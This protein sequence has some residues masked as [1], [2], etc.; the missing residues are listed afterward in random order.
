[1]Y[2]GSESI[3][4]LC[5]KKV[6]IISRPPKIAIDGRCRVLSVEKVIHFPP[7]SQ[8][9]FF[10]KPPFPLESSCQNAEK[11]VTYDPNTVNS[12]TVV[13]SMH[14]A[15][16]GTN[17]SANGQVLPFSKIISSQLSVF[18]PK[19]DYYLTLSQYSAT[20]LVFIPFDIPNYWFSSRG[21]SG[22]PLCPCVAQHGLCP[23]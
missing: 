15:D 9:F 10:S 5:S 12:Y 6:S 7:Y 4:A 1:M 2:V 11:Y 21:I 17:A 20:S 18:A 19:V 13:T 22:W 23:I 8:S 3:G 16:H 14:E